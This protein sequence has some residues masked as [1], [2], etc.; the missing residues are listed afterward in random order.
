MPPPTTR[1]IHH[2]APASDESNKARASREGDDRRRGEVGREGHG[3]LGGPRRRGCRGRR[4]HLR[5]GLL[6]L[7]RLPH[8]PVEGRVA[9][10]AD[11][12]ARRRH[13]PGQEAALQVRHLPVQP[14][15]P[16]E[17]P[18]ALLRPRLPQRQDREVRGNRREVALR[19]EPDLPVLPQ[20]RYPRVSVER[21]AAAVS[22]TVSVVSGIVRFVIGVGL[23]ATASAVDDGDGGGGGSGGGATTVA[24]AV[25]KRNGA[26]MQ[27]R[28]GV[29]ASSSWAVWI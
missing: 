26:S 18:Q 2:R 12:D 24:I 20:D 21:T 17:G 8:R 14:E 11:Q 25:C 9:A 27:S 4:L 22:I 19:E 29:G 13:H 7:A 16:R 15:C 23:R 1:A 5:R 3:R 6:G 10:A 28:S